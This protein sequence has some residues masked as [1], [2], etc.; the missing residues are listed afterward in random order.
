VQRGAGQPSQLDRYH[1]TRDVS[2]QPFHAACY[3]P[4][5]GL[6]FDNNGVVSVCSF[7]RTTPL[8][9]VGERPLEEM[10]RGSV[11]ERLRSALVA[12]DL[13]VACTLCAEEIDGGN[14]H[15]VVARG[16]DQFDAE[17]DHP[18]PRRMEFA[19][20]NACDLQCVMCSG[21]FSSSIRAHREGLPPVPVRYGDAFVEELRPFLP[22]L[23][24]ARFLGGEPFIATINHRIWELLA[25]L[26][27]TPDCN[28][29]TNGMHWNRRIEGHLERLPFSVGVSIDGVTRETVESVRVGASYDRIMANLDRFLEYGR[30]SGSPVSLTFCLMVQ[31]WHEFGDYLCF[32]EERGCRVYV[33]TV[34]HPP[35]NS[36]F[37]LPLE[38]LRPVVDRLEADRDRVASRLSLNG[39]VWTEQLD[40][41][42]GHLLDLERDGDRIGSLAASLPIDPHALARALAEVGPD[43]DAAARRLADVSTGPVSVIRC[44]A[45]ERIAAADEYLGLDV[46]DLAGS[47]AGVLFG[48]AAARFGHRVEILATDV[49]PG[50]LSRLLV[51]SEPERPPTVVASVTVAGPP[52]W[53]STRLHAILEQGGSGEATPVRAPRRRH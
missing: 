53:A 38:Q 48:R 1:A 30:R 5:V 6:S 33:N 2:H 34:R 3:A 11:A 15:S 44:D 25:Q 37:R 21:E 45:D 19:L 9:R 49:A 27:A 23:Q 13:D 14:F 41:L 12:D 7:T 22:H 16:F 26:G 24:Q 46:S 39:H 36:L 43:A 35:T 4:F 17:P 40:R 20:S 52:P 42:R 18:W 28:V 32:A 29:T 8:G 51:Y 47:P 31:N 10:W 50:S